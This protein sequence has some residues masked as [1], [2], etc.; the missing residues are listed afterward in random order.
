MRLFP[1]SKN[2][3]LSL[4]SRKVTRSKIVAPNMHTL[5]LNSAARDVV[6]LGNHAERRQRK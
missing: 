5:L 2:R 4:R 3:A 1:T 6:I